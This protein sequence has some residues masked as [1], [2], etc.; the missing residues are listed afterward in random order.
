L[1]LR[2]A[3][4]AARTSETGRGKQESNSTQRGEKKRECKSREGQAPDLPLAVMRKR[5]P[6]KKKEKKPKREDQQ[7]EKT[8]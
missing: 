7:K 4:R 8:P 6:R 3:E 5:R 2:L 1:T